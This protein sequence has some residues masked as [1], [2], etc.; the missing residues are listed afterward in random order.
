MML[1]DLS[2]ARHQALDVDIATETA[3]LVRH[4]IL[5][6]A[7]VAALTQGNLNSQLVV[8]LLRADVRS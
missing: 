8:A 3:E 4:Q 7:Q 5:Q 2:D 6:Q 1:E